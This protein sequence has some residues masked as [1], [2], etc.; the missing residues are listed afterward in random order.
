MT[1]IIFSLKKERKVKFMFSVG[2]TNQC[3][4]KIIIQ[5]LVLYKSRCDNRLNK[6]MERA[7]ANKRE[8]ER[9]AKKYE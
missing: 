1:R 2:R 8:V 3:S 4:K 9:L 5:E 6:I 7:M